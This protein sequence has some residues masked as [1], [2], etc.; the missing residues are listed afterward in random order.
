MKQKARAFVTRFRPAA[1][2]A[3]MIYQNRKVE[4]SLAASLVALV[5][6]FVH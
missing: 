5:R 1:K 2:L 3:K 6:S 4:L